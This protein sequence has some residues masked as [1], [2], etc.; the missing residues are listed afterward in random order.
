MPSEPISNFHKRYAIR[1]A[2]N[3]ANLSLRDPLAE[4]SL[5]I[6]PRLR[7]ARFAVSLAA[8][9]IIEPPYGGLPTAHSWSKDASESS[10]A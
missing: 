6:T 8:H 7:A 1:P 2:N 5:R 10:H 3:L 4:E 9:R